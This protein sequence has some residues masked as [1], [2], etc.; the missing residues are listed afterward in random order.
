MNKGTRIRG[1]ALLLTILNKVMVDMGTIDFGDHTVNVIYKIL[2][3]LVMI[4]AAV[5]AYWYNND[6][7]KVAAKHTGNMRQEKAEMKEGYV[8]ERFFIDENGEPMEALFEGEE[9]FFEEEAEEEADFEEG[10]YES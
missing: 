3:T 4:G 5:A 6:W 8:G 1:I 7:T 9:E 10:E 2:S